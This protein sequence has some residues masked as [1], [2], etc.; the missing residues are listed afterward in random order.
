MTRVL[1][2]PAPA[3]IRVGPSTVS[4]ASRCCSFSM[5][6]LQGTG[7][8]LQ[9]VVFQCCS[10]SVAFYIQEFCSDRRDHFTDFCNQRESRICLTFFHVVEPHGK[11][12]KGFG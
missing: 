12:E 10:S 2:D 11:H 1:P 7:D 8:R 4:T 5:I 9:G 6:R 3:R